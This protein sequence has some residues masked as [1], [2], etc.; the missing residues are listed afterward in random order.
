MRNNLPPTNIDEEERA[1]RNTIEQIAKIIQFLRNIEDWTFYRQFGSR[2]IGSY[3]SSVKYRVKSFSKILNKEGNLSNIIERPK[4]NSRNFVYSITWIAPSGHW[5]SHAL[6][7]RHSLTFVGEDL[8]SLISYTP[9]GQVFTHV[10]HPVHLG[11]TTIFT[12]FV[13][14]WFSWEAIE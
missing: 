2:T 11:S 1:D 13:Y 3:L 8:P 10:S 12:I 14:L 6:Q 9:T 7:T 5:A 4:L